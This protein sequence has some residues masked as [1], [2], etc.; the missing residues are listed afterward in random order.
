MDKLI[1]I[2]ATN[3]SK[4]HWHFVSAVASK[5]GISTS[6]MTEVILN[7][8]AKGWSPQQNNKRITRT[9]TLTK[10]EWAIIA[11]DSNADIASEIVHAVRLA[12]KQV[13]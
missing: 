2:K 7:G 1:T 8:V 12:E 13:A 11:A 9:V 6:E 5:N 10:M 3:V 4:H